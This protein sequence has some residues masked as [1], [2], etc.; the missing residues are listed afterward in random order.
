MH[1]QGR[2]TVSDDPDRL[3]L[4]VIHGYLS[5]SYWS[6]GVPREVVERAMR[7]SL[8]FGLYD[9]AQQ[10]GYGRVVTDRA[11]LAYLCDV[12][13]LETHQ[14]LGLGAWLVEC[15]LS[16]PD[17]HRL[18]RFMLATRDAHNLYERFGFTPLAHPEWMMER[19]RLAPSQPPATL[20]PA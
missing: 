8:P 20:L 11:V 3:D 5:R 1:P 2:F 10:V 17:L 4:D 18:K 13:V 7:G 16:H 9:G 19:V 12:F 14:G 15:V 6:P